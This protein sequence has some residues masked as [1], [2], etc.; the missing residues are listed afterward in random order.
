MT[1]QL[2]LFDVD[3][4]TLARTSDP[5]TSRR[6]AM[7][8]PGRKANHR[9]A[10]LEAY[11][12]GPA[13]DFDAGALAGIEYHECSRRGADLRRSGLVAPTGDTAPSPMGKAAR[14]CEITP[15]GWRALGRDD[16]ASG[17]VWPETP[18]A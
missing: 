6:A 13:T 17:E 14:V 8:T 10:L 9:R 5:S 3:G 18:N 15:A 12:R 4:R 11:A 1:A 7:A 2:S 16:I